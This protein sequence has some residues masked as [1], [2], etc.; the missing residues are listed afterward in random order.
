MY[1][2]PHFRRILLQTSLI[3]GRFVGGG[4]GI[5]IRLATLAQGKLL[6]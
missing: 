2:L 4:G 1:I 5:P 6:I 3:L